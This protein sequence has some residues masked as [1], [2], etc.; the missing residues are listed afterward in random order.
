MRHADH[1]TMSV[2]L[3]GTGSPPPVMTRFGPSTLVEAA[4]HKLIFDA[5][6]GAMQRLD[7][8]GVPW[9][10]VSGLFLSHLHSDHVVGIPDLWLTGWLVSRR[11]TPLRLWGPRG[12]ARMAG[13]LREAFDY[14]IEIRVRGDGLSPDGAVLVGADIREGVVFAEDGVTVTAFAVDHRP[15]EHAFGY[16]VEYG[17]YA[18]VLSGDTRMSENLVQHARGADLLILNVVSADSLRRAG[19]APDTVQRIVANHT[20]PEESGEIFARTRPR[21][22]VFSHIASARTATA[23]DFLPATRK[24]YSGPLE[25]GEDLMVIRIGATIMVERRS[26]TD[27]VTHGHTR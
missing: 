9:P 24:I 17:G 23:D 26:F 21:L 2:T 19:M 13:H 18:V 22:A 16:R 8:L 14:D 27:G 11:R 12:T 20:T 3:L 1:T 25:L 4:H 15:V 7:Q 10:E 5:G 6:R